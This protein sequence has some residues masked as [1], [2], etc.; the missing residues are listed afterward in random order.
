MMVEPRDYET[1][2]PALLT[3]LRKRWRRE[4][5]ETQLI[6][7]TTSIQPAAIQFSKAHATW[8][9]PTHWGFL[10]YNK[11]VVVSVCPLLAHMQMLWF[12]SQVGTGQGF[13]GSYR[14]KVNW[15]TSAYRMFY[16]FFYGL[17]LTR[18]RSNEFGAHAVCVKS[19]KCEV[20]LITGRTAE[21]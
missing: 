6:R 8:Q 2:T 10:V 11:C 4:K 20:K 16:M 12:S 13:L 18:S 14:Q 17:I 1:E 3:Y 21:D 7:S 5:Q 19:F 9:F 15:T